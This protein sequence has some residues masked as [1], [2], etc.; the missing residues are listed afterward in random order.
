MREACRNT[1]ED[2]DGSNE[3]GLGEHSLQ[4]VAWTHQEECTANTTETDRQH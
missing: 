4:L 1:D 2:Y 3:S